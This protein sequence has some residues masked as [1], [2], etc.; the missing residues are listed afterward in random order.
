[1]RQSDL[2]I[3]PK[4]P[5]NAG[6]LIG[7]KA[8]LKPKH[9]WVIRQQL[10]AARRVRDLAMFNCALDSK[11][12]ACDLVRLRV[13]D[14]APG[15][16]LRQ[17]SIEVRQKTGRPVPF[18]I[19]EPARDAVAT[20]LQVRGRRHDGWLFPSRSRPVQHIGT[21][22]YARLV[23][24]WMCMI[25]LEPQCYGTHSLRRTKVSLIYK[26]TGDLRACQLLLGHRKLES[27]VRYLGIEV[28]DVLEMSEQI[29]L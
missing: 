9:I 14:L 12:R 28:D 2:F 15:G 23:D 29:D 1:M 21:G 26:K 18:E 11:L 10:K 8:P 17:R 6:R 5:W 22:R 4:R 24:R 13:S 3:Q 19:T 16:V 25:E 7:P 20:W 27:T